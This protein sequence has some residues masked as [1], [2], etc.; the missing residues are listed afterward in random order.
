MKQK[1]PMWVNI[2][3]VVM[4]IIATAIVIYDT[5]YAG[6]PA[7]MHEMRDRPAKPTGV[8]TVST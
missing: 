1:N 6:H 3:A 2:L 7:P 4:A 5:F 8:K